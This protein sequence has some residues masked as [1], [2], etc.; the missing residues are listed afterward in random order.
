MPTE[1]D[2]DTVIAQLAAAD[3]ETVAVALLHSYVNPDHEQRLAKRIRQKLPRLDVS[4]SSVISPEIRE[5][6]RTSTTVLNALLQPV[7][8]AY[9]E[10]LDARMRAE[11]FAPNLLIVQSNGG[12]C[13]PA[14]AAGCSTIR[15]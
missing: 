3:I 15:W 9:I 6:E 4:L 5:Y 11:A 14:I 8:R 2:I 7:V 13:T 1:A 10:R 12:V